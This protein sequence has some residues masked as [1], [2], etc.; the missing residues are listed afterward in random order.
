MSVHKTGD[1][2]KAGNMLGRSLPLRIEAALKRATIRNALLL[3]REIK[4]GIRN[5]APGGESF[6]KLAESTIRKKGST[7]AL[8]NDGFLINAITQ[9]ILK[10]TAFVGLMRG[11]VN[12]KG[13]DL[14][15]IGAIMEYGATINH[16]NGGVIIIPP[17]PYMHPVM[18]AYRKTVQENYR[19]A[20]LGLF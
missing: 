15:N 8:I 17:R 16:P 13:E 4:K 1:W 5:Q 11:S 19:K 18:E 7:K 6:V 9:K 12:K 10:E 2:K 14:V 20:L 3:V